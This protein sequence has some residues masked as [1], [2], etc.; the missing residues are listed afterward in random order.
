MCQ[1]NGKSLNVTT[2]VVHN[3]PSLTRYKIYDTP[4]QIQPENGSK[5]PKHIAEGCKF[6]KYLI[7]SCV[8]LFY[9]IVE[10][11][12]ISH[13]RASSVFMD[14]YLSIFSFID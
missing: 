8:R 5:K 3:S 2:S 14:T 9:Y 13:C 10:L 11:Q 12:D 1:H 7:K 6:I 4:S